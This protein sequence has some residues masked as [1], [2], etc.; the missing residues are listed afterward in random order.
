[1]AGSSSAWRNTSPPANPVAPVKMIFM[2]S[3]LFAQYSYHWAMSLMACPVRTMAS[4][5][6]FI[7]G[8]DSSQVLTNITS[9]RPDCGFT[10]HGVMHASICS[11]NTQH[12]ARCRDGQSVCDGYGGRQ[13]LQ[14]HRA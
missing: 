14:R 11:A 7:P 9:A 5:M 6:G 12:L 13:A 2:V 8:N 4:S 3:L 10:N 1:M